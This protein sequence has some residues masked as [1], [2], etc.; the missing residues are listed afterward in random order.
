MY[1]YWGGRNPQ[2][3]FLY[4]PELGGYLNDH[5]LTGLNTAFSRSAEKNYV[6]DAIM[7]DEVALRQ[8]VE[9]GA[10][11]LVCGGRD[12]ASGVR[13]VFDS[14]LKP[15]HLNVD[16]LKTEGRYLEDVY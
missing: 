11:I 8:L 14:I 13:K 12:M 16:A 3:D 9:R 6:Q 4:Q 5:R 2:S 1:L 15:M 10:Q 7:A